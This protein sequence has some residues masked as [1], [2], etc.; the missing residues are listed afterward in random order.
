MH[1]VKAADA[2]RANRAFAA[3]RKHHV[4]IAAVNHPGRLADGV[5][6]RGA[7]RDR[8]HV[9]AAQV[10]ADAHQAGGHVDDAARN[11]E[12]RNA[13][14]TAFD[15]GLVVVADGLQTADARTDD[16]AGAVALLVVA[17]KVKA[18]VVEGLR[19]GRRGKLHVAVIT[20]G[21]LGL[22]AAG[23]RIEVLDF[24]GDAAAEFGSVKLGDRADAAFTCQ[25]SLPARFNIEP[26][27]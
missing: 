18:G 21:L 25:K 16:A 24:A 17:D 4:G 1:A 12:G 3:A 23:G 11:H 20:A 10:L 27:R 9:R 19:G 5:Q 2:H 14:R 22:Q 26:K 15:H 13:A 8:G 7:G 6:P